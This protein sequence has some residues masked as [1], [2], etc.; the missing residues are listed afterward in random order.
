MSSYLWKAYYEDDVDT[1]RQYLAS[2]VYGTRS[3][4]ARGGNVGSAVGSPAGYGTSPILAA[5]IRRTGPATPSSGAHG[6]TLTKADVN[7]RDTSGLTLLHHAAS[8]ISDNAIDFAT[9]LIEH[10]L[11]DLYVQDVENGWTALH[12]AF[13][14]GNVSIA[15]LM[16]ERNVGDA[17][18]RTTG[19][20]HQ[21]VGLIKVKDK[22]GNG[23]L[24]LFGATIKDR[25]LRPESAVRQ[26]LGSSGSD[27]ERPVLMAGEDD[28]HHARSQIPFSSLDADQLFTFGSNQNVT[29][30]FGDEDNR[31]FPE[32]INLR[33]PEHLIRR[34]YREH[35]V[36]LEKKW[37]AHDPSYQSA[38][39]VVTGGWLEDLPFLIRSKSLI[40]Q[41][42]YMAHRSSAILTTDPEANLYMCGHGQ[43]GRLGSGDE[44]TRYNFACVE[45]GSL[46]G[47][48]VAT[49][50]LGQNH[51]LALSDEGEIFS[52]GNNG[53]GQLGYSLPK[54]ALSDEDPISTIPRQIFGVLKRETVIGVSA[55]RIHSVAFTSTSLY[56]FGKNEGQLGIMDSDARSLEVQHT[57]RK[58]AASLFASPIHAVCA[59]DKATVCLLENDEVWVFANYGYAKI[60]F[61]LDGFTNHFLKQSFLVTTYD[62]VPN[63]IIKLTGGGDTICALSSRGEIYTLSIS[64]RPDNQASTSTTNPAKIRSAI[65]QPQCVW[66]PKKSNM[67]ARDVG[68]DAGGSIILSTDEGS[69]WKRTTRLKIKDATAS[70]TGEYKPK[71]YKFS[72]I[73]GLTRVLAVRASAHGAYAALRRDCDVLKTQIVV[74]E[75]CLRKDLFSLLPLKQLTA[76]HNYHA[77]DDTRPRFWQGAKKIDELLTLKQAILNSTD[78]EADIAEL[79]ERS[80]PDS[81][82]KCD[83]VLATT[84]SAVLIPV[85]RFVLMGRSRV[86]RREFRDLCEG[87]FTIPDLV[88]SELDDEGCTVVRFQADILTIVNLALYLY[89]DGIVDYWHMTR[90]APK[91]AH[92]YRQVRG[93]LMKVAS[94]L[95]LV[96]LE[97]AV[98]QMVLP[99]PCLNMDFEAAFADPA[100]FY[101]GDIVVQLEDEEVRVHSALVCARC[102][103]F[104]GLF[105]GRAGGRWLAGRDEDEDISVDLSHINAKTFRLVLRHI[106]ADTGAELFDDIV[107]V[108][109]DDFLDA[110]MDVMSAANEL[111][112]DRLSQI[113]QAVVGQFVNVR[114]VCELLNAISPSSVHEFKDAGLEY[115]CLNLE[116]MLQG[117]HLNALDEDLLAELDDVVRENQLACLP[118]AKSGRADMLL[119]ERHP[120][121]AAVLD[122]NRQRKIDSVTL[123]SRHQDITTFMPGSLG[124]ELSTSPLQQKARRRSSTAHYKT[125]VDRPSLKPKASAKDMMFAMD[126]EGGSALQTPEQSPSIRPMPSPRGLEAIASSPP[127]EVWYSSRGKVVLSPMLAPQNSAPGTGTPRTPRSPPVSGRTPSGGVPWTFTALPGPRTDMKNIMAQ[128]ATV[129][130]SSLSQDIAAARPDLPATPSSFSLGAPKLSQKDRKRMQ[131]SGSGTPK[132]LDSAP[133]SSPLSAGNPSSPWQD[134]SSPRSPAVH[135][136]LSPPIQSGPIKPINAR[137]SSTPHLTMRQT[138]ANPKPGQPQKPVIGPGGLSAVQQRS[139]PDTKPL[140]GKEQVR[141]PSKQSLQQLPSQPS[142]SKPIPQSIRHQPIP[143][144]VLG[145]TMYEIVALEQAAKD[146]LKAAAAKRDLQEIQAEQEFQEWWDKEAARVQEAEQRNATSAAKISKKRPS[147]GGGRGGGRAGRGGRSKAA[148]EQSS[149]APTT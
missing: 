102:P 92:R 147:R 30:G 26:R 106:Y 133:V 109:L 25:T 50:A 46:A 107:S 116:A 24:D 82:V 143:E 47:K 88:T 100:F 38:V 139:T 41:D 125:D 42:V 16:L 14:F 87:T 17:L 91:M 95:E 52:W 148:A 55:S 113:C 84:T 140:Q 22:E 142:N 85:H 127:E 77:D 120:E 37:S 80:L 53:Y 110:V 114:N 79:T 58:V 149:S 78:I 112:L 66:S 35:L 103:F 3:L 43:G 73:P 122:R 40:V 20:V 123:R 145:L 39:P 89:T 97:P 64:Q 75:P 76:G 90:L 108:G 2:S 94:K 49:V 1:F 12:R 63:R 118:F 134:V 27:E 104:E 67:Y 15:R 130:T 124:D 62:N 33:R 138:V 111:M 28:D 9:A 8:S 81:S 68:V 18:G 121:L 126:E 10:P 83:A 65:T 135:A 69:V 44:Q 51:T 60:Q 137:G 23:P 96:K 11:I 59:I 61:P 21:T 131:Q 54:S 5:K 48:R 13:Y 136:V 32:R 119:H 146:E 129:R 98:R 117:H 19:H 99:L 72:R 29:L 128:A 115:L 7:W 4:A 101:D 86:F 141:T 45:G 56:T 57:P 34:F 74:D 70:G 105:M 132:A 144:Q 71:D 93:E 31:Q 6:V 36:E